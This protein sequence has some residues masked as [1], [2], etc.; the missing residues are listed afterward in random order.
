VRNEDSDRSHLALLLMGPILAIIVFPVGGILAES[1]RLPEPYWQ[2][3]RLSS[4]IYAIGLAFSLLLES[5]RGPQARN[6]YRPLEIAIALIGFGVSLCF[7]VRSF[8]GSA[9]QSLSDC[10]FLAAACGGIL[11]RNRT[12]GTRACTFLVMA[13]A[14]L[15]WPLVYP[16]PPFVS[17]SLLCVVAALYC[18]VRTRLGAPPL[19]TRTAIA[20]TAGGVTTAICLY[21]LLTACRVG[22]LSGV[23]VFSIAVLFFGTLTALRVVF[24]EDWRVHFRR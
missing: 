21:G 19:K 16:L 22:S 17:V 3:L 8:H 12:N 5:E 9:W 6:D 18:L 24:G 14:R 13:A 7:L 2:A 4:S 11:V 23:S 15:S 10:L 20:T 1:S